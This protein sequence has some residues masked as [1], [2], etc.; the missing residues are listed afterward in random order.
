MIPPPHV[1]SVAILPK[2]LAELHHVSVSPTGKFGFDGRCFM[3]KFERPTQWTDSWEEAFR[4]DLKSLLD[5]ER[6]SQG[7][8]DEMEG[9]RKE[10][11]SKVVPRLLRPLQEGGRSIVPRLV[12]SDLWDGNCAE[13][14]DKEGEMVVFDA[15]AWFAHNECKW[16]VPC[17]TWSSTPDSIL[18]S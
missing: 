12:H 13:R 2:K 9:L 8:D 18:C 7:I 3:G 11:M 14:A 4:L 5:E 1:P 17:R 15:S 10:L 16:C 6:K